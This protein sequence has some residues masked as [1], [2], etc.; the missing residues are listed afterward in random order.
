MKTITKIAVLLSVSLAFAA[1]ANAGGIHFD[2]SLGFG[3]RCTPP[4]VFC[5][6]PPL[7]VVRPPAC[8]PGPICPPAIE[9]VV[10]ERVWVDEPIYGWV[11]DARCGRNIWTVVVPRG[12]RTVP[13]T[14]RARWAHEHGCYFYSDC[15][16]VRHSYRR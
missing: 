13:H 16:G 8:E 7:V 9:V 10:N 12:Y 6:P 4:P 1:R 11:F 15:H 5:A 14:Y 3:T 2:I